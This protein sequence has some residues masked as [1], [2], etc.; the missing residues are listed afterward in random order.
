M[1]CN[2]NNFGFN[3]RLNGISRWPFDPQCVFRE[4]KHVPVCFL[5]WL[6]RR[7][8]RVSIFLTLILCSN[9]CI[10]STI[11]FGVFYEKGIKC[12]LHQRSLWLFESDIL[13][14]FCVNTP[15]PKEV[16]V[17]TFGS[18]PILFSASFCPPLPW[19]GIDNP[20]PGFP[21]PDRTAYSRCLACRT[22]TAATAAQCPR[23]R[24]TAEVW[25]W[26]GFAQEGKDIHAKALVYNYRY[27]VDNPF[28]IIIF[29]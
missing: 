19:G 27:R 7:I 17:H 8:M 29:R 14:F 10:F 4:S 11:L 28:S 22:D 13:V 16:A 24:C 2:K 25:V 6:F 9:I 18:V 15:L 12:T 3:K 21:V 26:L 23:R 5:S 20:P 1:R